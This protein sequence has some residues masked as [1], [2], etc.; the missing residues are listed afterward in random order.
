MRLYLSAALLAALTVSAHAA[1]I[2]VLAP[3]FVYN[4]ALKDL[5]ADFTKKTGVNVIVSEG[6]MNVI[7]DQIKTATPAADVIALP[8]DLMNTLYLDGG[9]VHS[10]YTPLGRDELGLAVKKGAPKPDIST[11]EKLVTVLKSAQAVEV[12]DPKAGTMQAVIID[13]IV[14]RPEFAGVHVVPVSKGEGAGA[15]A[16]GEG[17][18]AIQ[19]VPEIFNKPQIDLV[20]PLPA[21]L[22]GH[23]DA[24]LAVSARAADQ[25]NALAFVKFLASPEARSAWV[26]KGL[27]PF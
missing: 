4:S 27:R 20:A 26:A 25:K 22:G 13:G 7:V 21:E 2:R 19:L 16:R 9:I 1:E 8:S 11:V 12:N 5:A 17:D 3:G 18:M 24:I 6:G 23:M 10:S 14:K 15:L